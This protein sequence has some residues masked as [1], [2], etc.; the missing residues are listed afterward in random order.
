MAF[1]QAEIIPPQPTAALLFWE[2]GFLSLLLN[3]DVISIKAVSGHIHLLEFQNNDIAGHVVKTKNNIM[4]G[5][6]RNVLYLT[7]KPYVIYQNPTIEFTCCAFSAV[8]IVVEHA[9]ALSVQGMDTIVCPTGPNFELDGG[10]GKYIFEKGGDEFRRELSRIGP[11]EV[12]R[13]VITGSGALA[14]HGLRYVVHAVIPRF[15]QHD[16]TKYMQAAISGALTLAEQNNSQTVG[17]PLMGSGGFEWPEDEAVEVSHPNDA[18]EK[19][20]D[21]HNLHVFTTRC[22]CCCCC[23]RRRPLRRRRRRRCRRRRCC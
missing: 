1:L 18:N 4:V 14:S 12:G 2:P 8:K 19:E 7:L 16:R 10:L 22:C 17:L 3:A 13:A 21:Y 9:D 6:E 5:T 23:R 15:R 20:T 11:Q